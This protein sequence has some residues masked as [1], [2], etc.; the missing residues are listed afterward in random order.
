KRLF[1]AAHQTVKY[2]Q[3]NYRGTSTLENP[4][5]SEL[6]RPSSSPRSFSHPAA[7]P[8]DGRP[9]SLHYSESETLF[10]D[11]TLVIV[12]FYYQDGRRSTRANQEFILTTHSVRGACSSLALTSPSC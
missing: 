9:P 3:V 7:I 10:L 8:R 6:I 2:K 11:E 1:D 5:Y 4:P 12:R